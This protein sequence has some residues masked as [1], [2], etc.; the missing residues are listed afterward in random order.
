MSS[1]TTVERSRSGAG[2]GEGPQTST[3]GIHGCRAI[4]AFTL[5]VS[6]SYINEALSG[7]C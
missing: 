3:T 5:L 7:Y 2:A 4:K 6:L 1:S